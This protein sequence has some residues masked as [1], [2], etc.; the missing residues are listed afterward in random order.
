MK[1]SRILFKVL[2][3]LIIAAALLIPSTFS[4]YNHNGS[5]TGDSMIYSR[6]KLPV[7]AGTVS[8]VTQKYTMDGNKLWYDTKGNKKYDGDAIDSSTST[9]AASSVQYYGTTF[10][11]TSSA[12]AYVNLYL[13]NFTNSPTVKIGTLQPS[14]TDKGLSS[15][16][17]LTNKNMIRVYFQPKTANNWK[18]ADAKY[19][20]VY[21][22]KSSSTNAYRIFS[23]SEGY[24]ALTD[25]NSK[26]YYSGK[27]KNADDTGNI[28]GG[29]TT[30]YIDLPENTTEYYFATDGNKSG[31][32]TS[33]CSVTMNWYRTNTITNVQAETGYYLTGVADDTTWNAQY[34]TFNIPGGVSVK[35]CFDTVT[36]N[37]NQHAYV[38]LNQ[39]TNY[40]GASA[41]YAVTAGSN[42]TVNG[43]TGYV[44][45]TNYSGSATITTTIKG[46]LGDQTTVTTAVSNPSTLAGVPVALNVEVPGKTTNEDNQEVNGTAEIVWYVDNSATSGGVQFDGIYYTK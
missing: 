14:L 44:T 33:D 41:T 10:T 15:S 30:Y 36:I 35:T 8:M 29:E 23:K 5:Q 20:V 3:V 43:N 34:A 22:T 2:V 32:N 12:P 17:H 6:Q 27:I 26:T 7:S 19:Y 25:S 9:V 40:T 4:W 1:K 28:L 16:V 46:S 18:E 45:T 39:G 38:T 13:K 21:K 42:I 24:N 37:K 11:N 31:F